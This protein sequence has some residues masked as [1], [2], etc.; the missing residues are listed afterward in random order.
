MTVRRVSDRSTPAQTHQRLTSPPRRFLVIG[1]PLANQTVQTFLQA[2]QG[3]NVTD[4]TL[5]LFPN[6][7]SSNTTLNT[8]NVSAQVSHTRAHSVVMYL[9]AESIPPAN[10][11]VDL[12]G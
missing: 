10:F 6:P 8:F 9:L 12:R 2:N 1:Y 4:E 7:N 11:G 5:A 3:F